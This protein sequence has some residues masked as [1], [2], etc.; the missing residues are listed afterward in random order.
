MEF[1]TREDKGNNLVSHQDYNGY[2]QIL[3]ALVNA[4]CD[5]A[6]IML[7]YKL[8]VNGQLYEFTFFLKIKVVSLEIK[9]K[10]QYQ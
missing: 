10:L 9:R 4:D 1:Y 6:S 5:E 3:V 2:D 7:K 8:L